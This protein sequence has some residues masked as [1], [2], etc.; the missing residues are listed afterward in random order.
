M[1]KDH[2]CISLDAVDEGE[3][4]EVG[5]AAGV[6]KEDLLDCLNSEKGRGGARRASNVLLHRTPP[7]F[8]KIQYQ[9]RSIPPAH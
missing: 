7:R 5:A 6:H 4:E 9:I 8:A 3:V 2:E 1:V